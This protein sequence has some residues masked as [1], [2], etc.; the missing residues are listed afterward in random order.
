MNSESMEEL[1]EAYLYGARG[2][3]S[4]HPMVDMNIP[5]MLDDSLVPD[6]KEQIVVT[7]FA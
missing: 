1:H 4:P 6:E 3:L 5:S 7:M 2:E